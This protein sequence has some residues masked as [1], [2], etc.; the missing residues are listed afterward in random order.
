[1]R[2]KIRPILERAK[3]GIEEELKWKRT[4]QPGEIEAYD[5]H[6]GHCRL[7]AA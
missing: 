1:V 7:N 3:V 6:A 2:Q 4:E 5:P